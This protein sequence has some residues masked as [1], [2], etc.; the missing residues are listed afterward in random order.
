[1]VG[2][3][4]QVLLAVTASVC[5]A[6]GIACGLFCSRMLPTPAVPASPPSDWATTSA[7]STP[8]CATGDTGEDTS[9]AVHPESVWPREEVKPEEEQDRESHLLEVVI[10]QV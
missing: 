8:P 9:F 6:L 5:L 3:I 10:G 2:E 1:M 7:P 4:A